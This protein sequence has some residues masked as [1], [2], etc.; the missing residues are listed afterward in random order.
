M[1]PAWIRPN[2][3]RD[4]GSLEPFM[5]GLPGVLRRVEIEGFPDDA[6]VDHS[7]HGSVQ[8]WRKKFVSL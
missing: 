7:H 5:P 6:L 1:F 4:P 3:Q 2:S 8:S